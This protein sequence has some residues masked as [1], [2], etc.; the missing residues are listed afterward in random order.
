M[1]EASDAGIDLGPA[2]T[3]GGLIDDQTEV[4]IELF[5]ALIKAIIE[6]PTF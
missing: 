2:R 6:R 3:L 4:L 1:K 5:K